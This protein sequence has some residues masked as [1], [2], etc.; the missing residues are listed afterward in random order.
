MIL[1]LMVILFFVLR[2]LKTNMR[3]NDQ[4]LAS[5]HT[6]ALENVNKNV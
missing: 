2:E 1:Y 5:F 3:E 6:K 4:I